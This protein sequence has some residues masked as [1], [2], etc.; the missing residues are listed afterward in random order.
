VY[1]SFEKDRTI[2]TV[3]LQNPSTII[4]LIEVRICLY[5]QVSRTQALEEDVRLDTVL[6]DSS[7]GFISSIQA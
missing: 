3:C 2:N 1:H 4:G 5:L 7:N 6:E